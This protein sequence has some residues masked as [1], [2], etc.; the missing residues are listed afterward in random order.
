MISK[1]SF[2]LSLLLGFL[3]FAS[4]VSGNPQAKEIQREF[5]NLSHEQRVE[6]Q[7]IIA[8]VELQISKHKIFSALI[9]LE[10]AKKLFSLDPG[11][12]LRKARCYSLLQLHDE[13]RHHYKQTLKVEPT[14]FIALN[15]LVEISFD[16]KKWHQ[17][18]QD[19]ENLAT[20]QPT[21]ASRYP[22]LALKQ[23]I[24]LDQLKL[25]KEYKAFRLSTAKN[26]T[27]W[28]DTALSYYADALDSL[29]NKHKDD[30]HDQ[31]AS[32]FRV[33]LQP[34]LHFTWSK[35]LV[36]AGYMS[37]HEFNMQRSP[38]DPYLKFTLE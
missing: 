37:G 34:K 22:L 15:S 13:A 23:L 28:S 6:Y 2:G 11:I 31:I 12:P 20:K 30:A 36:D 9:K 17:C 4:E 18:L 8:D 24:C 10:Q 14:N 26:Y 21:A 32:A 19:I 25:E 1:N 5:S 33:F 29:R 27:Y 38:K 16:Q 7:Q 3:C 35:P